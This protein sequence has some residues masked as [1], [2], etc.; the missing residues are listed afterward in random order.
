MWMNLK[1][2]RP[3]KCVYQATCGDT[4][5]FI[6]QAYVLRRHK[7]QGNIS[8]C[9]CLSNKD[10]KY[11]LSLDALLAFF[12]EKVYTRFSLADERISLGTQ[13]KKSLL[14]EHSIQ[15]LSDRTSCDNGEKRKNMYLGVTL[16]K[17]Q[18][19][20]YHKSQ[21]NDFLQQGWQNLCLGRIHQGFLRT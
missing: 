21:D 3:I 6:V 15:V 10:D 16:K 18:E 20:H 12:L 1:N 5:N 14:P 19:N 9:S 7:I 17:K 13:T 11:L 4:I 2:I 8:S